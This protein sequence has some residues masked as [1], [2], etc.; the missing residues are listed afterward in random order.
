MA[1]ALAKMAVMQLK[2][3]GSKLANALQQLKIFSVQDLLFHLPTRYEDRTRITPLAELTLGTKALI[4][5]QLIQGH[6]QLGKRRSLLCRLQDETAD[7]QLRFF[8]FNAQQLK[9]LTTPGIKL[10]C[11]G[12]V[13]AGY[14]SGIEMVH[15]EYRSEENCSQLAVAD[16]LTPI[17]ATTQGLQQITLRK[18]IKQALHLFDQAETVSELLPPPCLKLFDELKLSDALHYIHHPPIDASVQQLLDGR[19]ITQQRLAFEE[20]I[21]HQLGLVKF[22]QKFRAREARSLVVQQQKLQQRLIQSLPFQLTV[23]Q[24]KVMQEINADLSKRHPMLRLVQG[25][26]GSGKTVIAA[27][28]LLQAV[29][30]QGQAVLMAPTELLAEQHHRTLQQW[31]APLGIRVGWLC[32]SQTEKSRREALIKIADG[33]VDVIVGTHALFQG[34]VIFSNLVLLVIDEQHRFGVDQRLALKEKAMREHQTPHQLIMTATPIPRTLAMT[35]YADLDV[36]IIDGLPPGRLPI[37]SI[38]ISNQRRDEILARVKEHCQQGRQAYWVCTLIEDSEVLQAKAATA[39][40]E[41][42]VASLP[43]LSIGLV[44]GRLK[45][46]EKESLMAKFKAQEINLLVATTVIEVGVDVANATLMIIENAERLG[47][48]QLHQLRGRVG[49]GNLASYCVFLYQK[50]LSQIARKRLQVMRD[51]QDGFYIA[52]QD[53]L[54]RGPGEVLGVRQTG[55]MRLKVAD[56]CRDQPLLPN[57]QEASQYIVAKQPDL[58]DPLLDRWLRGVAHYAEV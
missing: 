8:H 26:V 1:I 22:R 46:E 5:G 58:V 42:L 11:F 51:S 54:I 53:L 4:E 43:E 37:Q 28:T 29:E 15:P 17:Y 16:R 57:I 50:P 47:L 25:D 55:L 7:I 2:G 34:K 39:V 49:R 40:W 56:L 20:L 35:A 30:N 31:F 13:R 10:R 32:G 38:L 23:A 45:S 3:V 36:S 9:Q 41:D 6:V 18:L 24:Q 27:L 21:A 52:E 19:H 44:H 14:Q 33:S 48:A 12:E